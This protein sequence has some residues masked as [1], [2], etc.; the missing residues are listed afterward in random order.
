MT[1][2][3]AQEVAA[4]RFRERCEDYLTSLQEHHQWALK[5]KQYHPAEVILLAY[6]MTAVDGYNEVEHHSRSWDTRPRKDFGTILGYNISLGK[7]VANFL[8]ECRSG[9]H[10][11]GLAVIVDVAK[12]LVENLLLGTLAGTA[13]DCGL[14]IEMMLVKIINGAPSA[15][16]MH[17]VRKGAATIAAVNGADVLMLMAM[18]GWMT[19]AMAIHYTKK[20]NRKR[21]ADQGMKFVK[22]DKAAND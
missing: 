7:A 19:E 5:G 16:T 9:P 17:G 11:R 18:F 15:Y 22:F 8:F 13:E 21:L 4:K 14:A 2:A 20:A 1:E 3:G 6:L 10:S 12:V